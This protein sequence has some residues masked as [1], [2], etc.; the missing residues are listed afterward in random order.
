MTNTQ[1]PIN[2]ARQ[3]QFCFLGHILRIPEDDSCKGYALFV[4]THAEENDG[5]GQAIYISYVQKLL[6]DSEKDLHQDVITSLPAYHVSGENLYSPQG[7]HLLRS[8]MI[9]LG[10]IFVL[11]NCK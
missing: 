4:P 10:L 9:I 8:R 6:G 3:R 11:V 5:G 2:A 1:P 7:S